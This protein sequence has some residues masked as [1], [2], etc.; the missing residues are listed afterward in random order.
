VPSA[1][2]AR[3]ARREL[4][5]L[6]C[7]PPAQK[8]SIERLPAQPTSFKLSP[9]MRDKLYL[10]GFLIG[11]ALLLYV[12]RGLLARSVILTLVLTFAGT[13]AA[14]ILGM[15]LYRV[16]D[17]LRASQRELARKEAELNFA[18][19]VQQSLFPR[20]FPADGGL[21]FSAV[22]VPASG[23]SGDYYDVVELPDGRVI[24]A[25][26]DI[27][28]KGISAAILMSNLQAV[29]RIIAGAGHSPGEVCAQ[30]NR[31]LYHVTDSNRFAT[32]FYVEW[33]RSQRLLTYVNAGHPI[34]IL[35]G[36][37]CGQILQDGGPPL[38]LF[39]GTDF[40]V[41]KVGLVPGDVIVLYSDG[42]TEA[43]VRQGEEFGESR[44]KAVVSAHGHKPLAEIQSEVLAAVRRWS[45]HE[46]EDDMTLLIA[47]AT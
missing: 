26:A 43:G 47:R 19:E 2:A 21:E 6:S 31:H 39:L 9:L 33:N 5:D 35:F 34:P 41:G 24:F 22:C 10:F 7:V 40:G 1:C 4:P 13:T 27:S 25:I 45:G 46:P 30:L 32:I 3:H 16:Q 44:L 23:I 20:E 18:L 12:G 28:G 8:P 29:L 42:I 11:S 15:A 17:A 38:G 14:G 37:K 36:S